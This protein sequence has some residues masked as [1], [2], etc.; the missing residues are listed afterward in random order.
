[1]KLFLIATKGK[2]QGFPIPIKED[3]FMI[4]TTKECQMRAKRAGIGAQHCC[5]VTRDKK[6]VFV[7][8]LNSGEPT[9][10][11]G[12]LVP[13]GTEWPLHAGDKLALGSLEFMVQ[14]REKPLSQRDLEEW[15]LKCL[16]VDNTMGLHEAYDDDDIFNPQN[17]THNASSAA[18]AIFDKLQ[19]RRGVVMGRLR[20]GLEAGVNVVRFNDVHLVDPAE[21]AL[22]KKELYDNLNRSNLRILLDFKNVRRMSSTAVEMVIEFHQFVRGFGNSLVL[23]RIRPELQGILGTLRVGESLQHFPDKRMALTTRW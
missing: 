9:L 10:V 11:N 13:P 21:I 20:I 17:R 14:F 16:D 18:S 2:K 4:G 8:D 22:V 15:A 23:C 7:R 12:E 19:A 6:K 1:M 5:L 3:L